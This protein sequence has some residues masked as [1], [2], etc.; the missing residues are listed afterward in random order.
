MILVFLDIFSS[1]TSVTANDG[2]WH[3][4][5]VSWESATGSWKF[6]KDGVV[7]HEDTDFKRG[8]T[9]RQGGTLVLGQEQDS[10]GGGFDSTQSFQGMLSF[11]NV[12]DN[13][14]SSSQ[15][16]EMSKSCQKAEGGIEGNVY[17]WSDFLNEGGARLLHPSP[18]KEVEV[19]K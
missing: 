3:H 7:K 4:I 13:V 11:V 5:C 19:G 1:K 12:W 6:Y 2:I 14:L 18:C 15:I 17:K 8:Y 10:V 16:I 9:I